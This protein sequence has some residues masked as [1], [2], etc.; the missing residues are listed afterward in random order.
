MALLCK[1]LVLLVAAFLLCAP[2]DSLSGL[3]SS[4]VQIE[5]TGSCTDTPCFSV[6]VRSVRQ[7]RHVH[8][9]SAHVVASHPFLNQASEA[10]RVGS[11]APVH[12]PPSLLASVILRN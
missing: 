2:V 8:T 10:F 9:S 5:Q 11:K 4:N 1:S 7:V 12:T 3:Q 6:S